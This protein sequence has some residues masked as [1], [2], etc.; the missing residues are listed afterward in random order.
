MKDT[1]VLE[2]RALGEDLVLY[3]DGSGTLGL[4][5]RYCAHRR[6]NLA[7][8]IPETNG[9][10]CMYHGWLYSETGQCIEQ[11]F[12]ETV[13]PE[14]RFRDKIKLAGYPVRELGG[15]VWAYLGPAPAPLLPRWDLLVEPDV[16]REVASSSIPCNWLQTMEN[17]MDGSHLEH[18]HWRYGK[19]V[20][21]RMGV[22][23]EEAA[24]RVRGFSRKH[25]KLGFDVFDHGIIKRRVLE[26]GSKEE[27]DWQVGHPMVFP[28][29]MRMGNASRSEFQIRVPVD[30][31]NTIQW[32]VLVHRPGVDVPPQEETPY[33]EVPMFDEA[34]RYIIDFATGQDM[35]TWV[36][37]GSILDRSK[38]SLGESDRGII[39]YR[40]LLM[41]QMAINEDGGDPMNVIRD[42]SK[43]AYIELPQE[44]NK[45]HIGDAYRRLLQGSW[46][47]YSPNSE[48]VAHL[49][50]QGAAA[51][52]T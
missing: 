9:L 19:Y 25:V 49:Y 36:T 31:E 41:E 16:F 22:P 8:G 23:P 28:N 47:R 7:Y 33:F 15:L 10:R 6:V 52:E 27:E 18:L 20:L 34:G 35:M 51:R 4:I 13:R 2:V 3:K 48:A 46:S 14:S 50:M 30:D 5:E 45:Y 12:E 24:D 42:P 40:R 11:P 37:Q 43:N 39:L 26:G 38:E 21:E 29:I 44:R 17:A 32:Y 1:P